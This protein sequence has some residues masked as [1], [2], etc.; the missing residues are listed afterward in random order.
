M[1]Q[2]E[3]VQVRARTG[4]RGPR[5]AASHVPRLKGSAGREA[6]GGRMPAVHAHAHPAFSCLVLLVPSRGVLRFFASPRPF[7][8]LP[9]PAP[10]IG[11]QC[12]ARR[13]GLESGLHA[14]LLVFNSLMRG[15]MFPSGVQACTPARVHAIDL[16]LHVAAHSDLSSG[17]GAE[18]KCLSVARRRAPLC[19]TVPPA[20]GQLP[21]S[22]FPEGAL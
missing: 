3:F 15:L 11:P 17:P 4:C 14:F 13:G 22:A 16:R 8:L 12:R 9:M 21:L 7:C 5:P 6:G 2:A 18:Q 20:L 1:R 10:I 19:P